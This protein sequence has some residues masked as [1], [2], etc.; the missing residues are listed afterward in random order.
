MLIDLFITVW[1][2][3]PQLPGLDLSCLMTV[4]FAKTYEQNHKEKTKTFDHQQQG[5]GCQTLAGWWFHIWDVIL[6]NWRTHI[7]QDGYCTTNQITFDILWG[8]NEDIAN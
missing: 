7:F 2:R 4:R 5:R 3:V 1:A 8:Y 6:P